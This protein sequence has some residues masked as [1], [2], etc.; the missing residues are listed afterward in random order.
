MLFIEIIKIVVLG[1]IEGVTEWL[2]ISST[3]HMILFNELVHLNL[4]EEFF[5]L[6][7]VVIQLGA[8]LAVPVLFLKRLNPFGR[9]T[10]VGERKKILDLWVKVIIGSLPAALF[11]LL[12]DRIVEELLY[13]YTVVALALIVFGVVFI[14]IEKN[15]AENK[16]PL[17]SLDEMNHL[18]ALKIG[19]MQSLS[20]IPGTSRSGATIIGG[21]TCGYTREASAEFSFFMAIPIII[22]ASFL[23]ILKF[24]ISGFR[25]SGDELILLTV[26]VVTA[27]AVSIFIIE[28][29]MDFVKKHSFRAFGIYRIILGITVLLYFGLKG[30]F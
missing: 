1:I 5:S 27:F 6:L 4:S 29:L 13:G 16:K 24:V 28:F 14:I 2:P 7:L 18:D 19:M 3:G 21:M 22:G 26:G 15:R 9:L 20:I 12:F 25:A 23:R 30:L 17:K 8:I 11:G 10:E